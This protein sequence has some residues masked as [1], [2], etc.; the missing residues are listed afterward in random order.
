MIM[1]KFIA[2]PFVLIFGFVFFISLLP[3]LLWHKVV[4][5]LCSIFNF[6]LAIDGFD[7]RFYVVDENEED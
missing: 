6:C 1:I 5:Y 7:F 4:F 3:F 2:L